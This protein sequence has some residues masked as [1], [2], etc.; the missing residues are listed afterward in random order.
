MLVANVNVTVA[1][2]ESLSIVMPAKQNMARRIKGIFVIDATPYI[3]SSHLTKFK[4]LQFLKSWN[5]SERYGIS[6]VRC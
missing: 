6:D 1:A 3:N 4:Y 2:S 5:I